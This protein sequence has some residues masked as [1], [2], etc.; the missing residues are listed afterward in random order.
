MKERLKQ[1]L[2]SNK[3][4]T[5]IFTIGILL[6]LLVL[7]TTLLLTLNWWQKSSSRI[8]AGIHAKRYAKIGIEESIWEIDNDDKRVDTHYDPWKVNFLG[9][10]ID[11]NEDGIPDSKW[12]YIK[13]INEKII[14]RYAVLVEDENENEIKSKAG[15]LIKQ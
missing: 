15:I 14:G 6:I 7:T 8:S 1:L 4:D 2:E 9:D 5:V 11:V 3:G 12:F 10:D 13:D